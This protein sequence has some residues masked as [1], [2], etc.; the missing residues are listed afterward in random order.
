MAAQLCVSTCCNS[1]PELTSSPPARDAALRAR[2]VHLSLRALPRMLVPGRPVFCL[3]LARD[4]RPAQFHPVHSWRYTIMCLLGLERAQRAGYNLPGINLNEL[5]DATVQAS[6]QFRPGDLGLLLW[7]AVRLQSAIADTLANRLDQHLQSAD[8]HSFEGMEVAWIIAGT[9]TYSHG[10]GA[11]ESKSSRRVVDYFF[12]N[13]V[14]P[15]GLAWHFGRGWR[16]RF[17]NFATQIYSVHALSLRARLLGDERCAR[18]AKIIADRLGSMQRRNGGWPWL[19]DA[20]RG[21]VVEPFEI[22]SVHQHAMAPMALIEL[23]EA[24]GYAVNEILERSLAWLADNELQLQMVDEAT[25]LLYRSIR[26]AKPRDRFAIYGRTLASLMGAIPDRGQTENPRGLELNATC[27]PYE[28]G[29]LLEAWAGRSGSTGDSPV[30][31]GGSPT[32]SR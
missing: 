13:R 1:V 6:S 30:L 7:L 21:T 16:K 28:L 12:Q 4:N 18:Q 27:R 32:I 14:S 9:A 20:A 17:P 2:L 11:P 23:H 3:E 29:W 10:T 24:T 22:Y 25:G 19:Y 26:R 15:S 31:V 5:F 8:L